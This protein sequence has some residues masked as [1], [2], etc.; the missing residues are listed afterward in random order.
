MSETSLKKKIQMP[1]NIVVDG[2]RAYLPHP[3]YQMTLFNATRARKKGEYRKDGVTVVTENVFGDRAVIWAPKTLF[4]TPDMG[5]F[6]GVVACA[7]NAGIFEM[8]GPHGPDPFSLFSEFLMSDLYAVTGMSS[9]G[10]SW[11]QLRSSLAA[12]GEVSIS[13]EYRCDKENLRKHGWS[14]GF[15]MDHFWRMNIIKRSGRKGSL[16]RL[17]PSPFL[18]PHDYYLWADAELCNK[19]KKDTARGVFWQLIC[20][21]HLAGTAEEWREWLNAS[22]GRD[23][24]V[25]KSRCLMPALEELAGYGYAVK[26]NGDEITVSRPSS[27]KKSLPKSKKNRRK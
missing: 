13:V 27:G 4:T 21:E 6:L 10:K 1:D 23:L 2:K 8:I 5:V 3:I 17:Y 14:S 22:D 12:L 18:I 15:V 19:L 24:K 25:W 20:R 9:R 7:Q 11:Y 16:V 26:E